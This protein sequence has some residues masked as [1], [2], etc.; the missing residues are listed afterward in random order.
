MLFASFLCSSLYSVYCSRVGFV[1]DLVGIF[2]I[3]RE[4]LPVGIIGLGIEID[5]VVA[6]LNANSGND[7]NNDS[8]TCIDH[9]DNHHNE[10]HS[11][12]TSHQVKAGDLK[13][14]SSVLILTG[15]RAFLLLNI[16]ENAH[17]LHREYQR[18]HH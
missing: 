14:L 9:K 17:S 4:V 6:T 5:T 13:V 8:D 15:C 18:L 2:D 16:S 7:S 12:L 11:K 1:V 10:K 3:I